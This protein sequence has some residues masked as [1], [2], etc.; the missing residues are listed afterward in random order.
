M[1]PVNPESA[2]DEDWFDYI[3]VRDNPRGIHQ[4]YWQHIAGCRSYVKV[5]RN[6]V[7]HE[8]LKTGLPSDDLLSSS[9]AE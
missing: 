5:L 4:E 7:T 3:Y 8:V 9:E 2:T 1:R 6:T